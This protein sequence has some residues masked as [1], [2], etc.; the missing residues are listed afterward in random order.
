MKLLRRLVED[1]SG[2]SHLEYA[3]I[4]FTLGTLLVGGLIYLSEG[5]QTFFTNTADTLAKLL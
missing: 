3:I 2:N 1:E 5:L 4:A